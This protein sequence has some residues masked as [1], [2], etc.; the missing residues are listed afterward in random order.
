MSAL[1]VPLGIL[2][3]LALVPLSELLWRFRHEN[4]TKLRFQLAGGLWLVAAGIATE[5]LVCPWGVL[6]TVAGVALAVRALTWE[7]LMAWVRV[8]R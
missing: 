8:R 5:R 1:S 3:F 2:A 4:G 6:F 7:R